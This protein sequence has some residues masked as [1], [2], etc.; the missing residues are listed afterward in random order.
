MS[1][2]DCPTPAHYR[3]RDGFTAGVRCAACGWTVEQWPVEPK[4]ETALSMLGALA[5]CALALLA[6]AVLAILAAPTP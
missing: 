3:F 6:V 5:C 4:P 2:C 1:G